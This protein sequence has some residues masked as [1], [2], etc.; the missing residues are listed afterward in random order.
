MVGTIRMPYLLL[1]TL[2]LISACSGSDN[3]TPTQP[4]TPPPQ[5]PASLTLTDLVVGTGAEAANGNTVLAHYTVWRYDPAGTD[6]KGEQLGTSRTGN[7]QSF[8]LGGT[9]TI[10]GF[11]QTLAGMKVGGQR[12]AIVPPSLAYGSTGDSQGV[13]RPNEWLVFEV[14]LL[15]VV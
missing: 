3:D 11:L 15:T 6:S 12:R 10:P 9:G 8:T 4:S 2:L 1:A 7:P 5:G 14:E 13:V